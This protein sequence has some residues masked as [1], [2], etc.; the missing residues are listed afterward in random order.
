MTVLMVTNGHGEDLLAV[1]LA[2]ALR[3]R[4]PWLRIEAIPLVGEGTR[5][6]QA[7]L[8][9]PGPRV[10]VPSGGMV[11]PQ[12]RTVVRDLRA[13]LIGQ[14]RRQMRFVASRRG[15]AQYVIAVGDVF[16]G[17]AAG[18]CLP[19]TPLILVATAK[20]EY[21]H[22]HSRLETWWMKRRA[23]HVFARDERTAAALRRA[24]VAASWVGNLMMDAMTITGALQ[25]G[26]AARPVVALLPGSREDAYLNL[27]SL[28]AVL[29]L[30]AEDGGVTG[31]VPLAPGLDMA[32]AAEVVRRR[33]WVP[34]R[35]EAAG[36]AQPAVRDEAFQKGRGFLWILEG[37]FGDVLAAA[38][39][40]I[41][42]AGTGNEQ[43]AGLGKP[44]VAFPGPGVQFGPRFMRAQRLLLGE[45]LA[46]T[47]PDPGAVA[48]EVRAILSD[49]ARRARMA[50]AGRE[51]M[52]PPGAADRMAEAIG[53]LWKWEEQR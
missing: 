33:G 37:A 23:Q 44:V 47:P 28:T 20:S 42:L 1:C 43:A 9:V 49:P 25:L 8:A 27:D 46:V 29:E 41:G 10:R 22:G 51:R 38:D 7:G 2:D 52:G 34:A 36:A 4:W 14:M 15:R 16:A 48:A 26:A 39:V 21:I 24:G 6:A 11:R 13:G 12:W 3:R 30:L 50:A 40:V 53:R 32:R 19:G 35:R 5:L 17:W 45:A 31:L 18:R